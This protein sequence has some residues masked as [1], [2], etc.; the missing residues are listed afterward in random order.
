MK[1]ILACDPQGGIG[2]KN[3]L[4][5]TNL[6]GDLA[7]FKR[8]TANQTVVMGR[9]TWDSLPKKPLPDRLNVVVSS[10]SIELPPGVIQAS[11]INELANF[12]MACVIGG[13]TLIS[14]SWDWI[15]EIHLTRTLSKYT[16]DTYIDLIKLN[17]YDLVS[18]ELH[19]DHTYEIWKIK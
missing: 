6:Q 1:L 17:D 5:W 11:N 10:K 15:H 3:R 13:A 7:R 4:P 2:Y 12:P 19:E 14:Q 16:C 8:L 9:K 18:S